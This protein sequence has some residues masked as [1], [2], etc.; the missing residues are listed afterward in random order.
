MLQPP[1]IS[2]KEEED[3]ILLLTRLPGAKYKI[4]HC[5]R[6]IL[7]FGD[8]SERQVLTFDISWGLKVA[9]ARRAC[10]GFGC[11]EAFNI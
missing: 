11:V 10:L 2:I 8:H 9:R 6:C 3:L 5:S 7:Q 4:L 1:G